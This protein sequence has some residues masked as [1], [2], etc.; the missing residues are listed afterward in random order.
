MVT[1]AFEWTWNSG[2]TPTL[3]TGPSADHTGGNALS[4]LNKINCNLFLGEGGACAAL[5]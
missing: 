3:M 5:N 1:D 4:I 2:S